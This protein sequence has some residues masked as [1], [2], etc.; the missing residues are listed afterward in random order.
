MDNLS[1]RRNLFGFISQPFIILVNDE[2]YRTV[3]MF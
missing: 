3:P 1:S 2:L